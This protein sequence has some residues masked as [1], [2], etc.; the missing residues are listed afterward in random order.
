VELLGM[1]LL[2]SDMTPFCQRSKAPIQTLGF[3]AVRDGLSG[4]ARKNDHRK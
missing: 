3:A 2:R 4:S 1:R